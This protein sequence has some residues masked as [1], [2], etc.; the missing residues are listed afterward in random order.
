MVRQTLKNSHPL[1][2]LVLLTAGLAACDPARIYEKNLE[3]PG[4][5]WVE[6]SLVTFEFEVPDSTQ[7]YNVYYNVRNS[8]D[9]PFY[10]LYLTYYLEDSSGREV[11]SRLQELT[12]FDP[13]TGEPRGSSLSDLFDHQILGLPGYRF[14][15]AGRYTF[16]L[17][18][19]MR[20]DPLPGVLNVGIRVERAD[21]V[22][23]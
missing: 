10:N 19:Y 23:E 13:K 16:K 9:Y 22:S 18:Q 1:V 15:H 17:K 4:A 11:S 6:D 21:G 14:P 7:A 8:L 2:A 5:S 3:V 20:Q 12:L